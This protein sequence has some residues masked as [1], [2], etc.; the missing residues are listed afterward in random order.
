MVVGDNEICMGYDGV[1]V[2]AGPGSSG[3]SLC[4]AALALAGAIG[5]GTWMGRKIHRKF[6]TL[7]SQADLQA[8]FG[9]ESVLTRAAL[10]RRLVERTECRPVTAYR[11]IDRGGYLA[12]HLKKTDNGW[13]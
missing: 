7:I 2:M 10:V 4:T 8:A 9:S 5:K 6:K 3:K 12:A 13:L 1:V 11:A